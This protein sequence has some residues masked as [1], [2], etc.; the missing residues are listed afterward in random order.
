MKTTNNQPSC[1]AIVCAYN[2]EKSIAGVL[3][4]LI[5]SPLVDEIIVVDDGSEDETA[6][7]I[8]RFASHQKIH[9]VFLPQN[10][11]KGYAMAEGVLRA[12]GE[13]LFF[14]DADLLNLSDAHIA[15]ILG[16]WQTGKA[17]MII[18]YRN[19]R[20]G[21]ARSA[22]LFRAFSGERALFRKDILPL[23]PAI[24]ESQYGVETLINLHYRDQGK[25]IHYASLDGLIHPIKTKKMRVGE[26][27]PMFIEETIQVVQAFL[28]HYVGKWKRAYRAYG[29][30][31]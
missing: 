28:Q 18:G 8:Q 11:G 5:E 24:K 6:V 16:Q 20:R 19:F 12:K 2:E 7:V 13:T 3:D 9:P 22:I 15:K 17:D 25:T 31:V 21:A 14:V 26:A 23:V 30:A 27:I 29:G 10:Q 4:A 1:T